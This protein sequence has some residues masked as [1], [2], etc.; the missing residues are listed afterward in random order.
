MSHVTGR[1]KYIGVHTKDGITYSA[2]SMGAGEQRVIKILQ[3]VYHANQYSLILIDEIDLL[4]HADAFRKLINRLS[5]I[6]SE[7]NLQI[8]FTTH[9]MEMRNLSQYV[10]IRYIEQQDNKMLVYD[11]I[12]PDL[13]YKL[14]GEMEREYSIYVEDTFAASIVRKVSSELGMQRH[15]NIITFG[16]IENAFTVAAGKVLSRD[17]ISKILIVTDGDKFA[18]KEEKEKRLKAVLTGTE[19]GHEEK[20]RNALSMLT[21]FNLPENTEPEKYVHSML[22]SMNDQHECIAC[23]KNITSVSDS[24]E[25][26]DEI[27]KQMGIGEQIYDQI[28]NIVSKHESWEAY[29]CSVRD[30]LKQKKVEIDL[31]SINEKNDT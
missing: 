13:V 29:V 27:V 8:I 18:T 23:A 26:I 5:K 3:T 19:E 10:D 25:W 7:K 28:M 17:D 20:V 24:H 30:W 15:I 31:I 9:S 16:S 11:S 1:K 2:L 21:Q 6:S 22:I 12:K 14:S 4:L